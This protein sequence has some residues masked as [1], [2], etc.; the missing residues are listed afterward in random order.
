MLYYFL[1]ISNS[2]LQHLQEKTDDIAI[3]RASGDILAR[4]SEHIHIHI[5]VCI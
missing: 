1:T 5:R 2:R 4:P 3:K